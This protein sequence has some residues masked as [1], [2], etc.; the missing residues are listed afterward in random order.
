MELSAEP[1][2]TQLLPEI[3]LEVFDLLITQEG[4]ADLV[5]CIL[6]CQSWKSLAESVLY[7][8]VVLDHRRL[9]LFVENR[10][11]CQVRS[12]TVKMEVAYFSGMD[13]A[14]LDNIYNTAQSYKESL[15]KLAGLMKEIE[16]ASLS[17]SATL[18]SNR[19]ADVTAEIAALVDGLPK[20]CTGLEINLWL[21]R[22]GDRIPGRPEMRPHLCNSIR[23]I[24]PQLNHLRLRL[25]TICNSIVANKP[26]QELCYQSI[27]APL[28]E[29]CLIS[30]SLTQP[31]KPLWE[32]VPEVCRHGFKPS[33]R[34]GLLGPPLVHMEKALREFSH[35]NSKNLK[36]MWTIETRMI[37]YRGKQCREWIRRDFLSNASYFIIAWEWMMVS[38][39]VMQVPS[40]QNPKVAEDI[41]V[42]E[43]AQME[44][45][46]EGGTWFITHGGAHIPAKDA[47]AA[48]WR[49]PASGYRGDEQSE[50]SQISDGRTS[51]VA[52]PQIAGELMRWFW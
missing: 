49:S 47:Q 14:Q 31:L 39:W 4:T 21:F 33:D 26:S 22:S 45:I 25:P 24:L 32:S 35:L 29:T 2:V 28:L 48:H 1:S 18:I 16:P 5:S 10:T 6:C 13:P 51:N 42:Q 11:R 37:E 40:L 27:R 20:S 9:A 3:L 30:L 7:R 19:R 46:A 34:R 36:R 43:R 41:V 15:R 17:L 44:P 38:P 50:K 8:H 23:A 12:L 52:M